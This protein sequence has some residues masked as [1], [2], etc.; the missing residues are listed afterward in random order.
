MSGTPVTLAAHGYTAEVATIGATLRALQYTGRDLIVSF[1]MDEVRPAYRGATLAPWPNRI[2]DGTYV[3]DGV[4]HVTALTEPDRRHALH[5][6]VSWADF[7][8][9]AQSAAS[10]SLGTT[11]TPQAGY[12]WRV[13]IDTTFT[14]TPDGLAQTVTATNVGPG[15]APVGVGPHPYVI[16]GS[17]PLDGWVMQV[18][19][20]RVLEVT[21]D[22]LAPIDVR[23]IADVDADRFDFSEPRE[24]GARQIDH[25]FTGLP[26][27]GASVIVRDPSSGTGVEVSWDAAC[28]WVQVY[29]GDVDGGAS[30]PDNRRGLAVEPMTCAPDAFNAQR[31]A[32]DTGLVRLASQ[33][34]L[35]AGW[36]IRAL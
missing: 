7:E 16:A 19:A 4:Q 24:I 23:A 12:P 9:V 26:E 1:E 14:I 13:R 10:V 11:I 22:R 25:A 34:Q 8:V 20:T 30:N 32:F 17:G 6:L 15:D 18:P 36:R 28:P 3:L 33:E 21:T 31:Y 27:G 5:G 2:V 35:T 29:T